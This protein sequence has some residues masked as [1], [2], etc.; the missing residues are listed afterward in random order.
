MKT[1]VA[2]AR[3][4]GAHT[5]PQSRRSSFAP[6]TPFTRVRDGKR[7]SSSRVSTT[8]FGAFSPEWQET[9]LRSKIGCTFSVKP[10]GRPPSGGT[11]SSCAGRCIATASRFAVADASRFGSWQPTQLT[12]SPGMTDVELRIV[13][14][15]KP[16]AS[17]TWKNSCFSAGTRK[18]AEPSAST[19]AV[20]ITPRPFSCPPAPRSGRYWSGAVRG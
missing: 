4:N 3:E 6:N 14:H 7:G 20:P 15:V 18:R 2:Y 11:A 10:H 17:R 16:S 8:P 1:S 12:R 19:S 9:H 13:R 5:M